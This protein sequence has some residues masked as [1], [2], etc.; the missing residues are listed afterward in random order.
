MRGL[1]EKRDWMQQ[2]QVATAVAEKA[3]LC[4]EEPAG[5]ARG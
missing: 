1:G 5:L 3:V 4:R 2:M